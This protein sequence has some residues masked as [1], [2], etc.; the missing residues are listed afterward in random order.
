MKEIMANFQQKEHEITDC[1]DISER[2]A[3]YLSM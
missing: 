2:A 3:I 1:M